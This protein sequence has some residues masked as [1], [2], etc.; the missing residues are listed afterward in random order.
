MKEVLISLTLVVMLSCSQD[1]SEPN[2]DVKDFWEGKRIELTGNQ[3]ALTEQ[4]D[5][6]S[7]GHPDYIISLEKHTKDGIYYMQNAFYMK[8][9]K[10]TSFLQVTN[11]F[12]P[13]LITDKSTSVQKVGDMTIWQMINYYEV[14]ELIDKISTFPNQALLSKTDEFETI[15]PLGIKY[16]PVA[17]IREGVTYYGWVEVE[18][19]LSAIVLKKAAFCRTGDKKI[20][21]G[22]I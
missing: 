1:E 3:I 13:V 21:V 14:N 12:D 16:I 9:E 19:E 10:V 18:L 6:N 4:I 7:D 5:I 17:M 22:N 11:P 20:K 8:I 15:Q 2:I